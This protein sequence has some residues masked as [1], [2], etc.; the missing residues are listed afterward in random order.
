MKLLRPSLNWLLV[1][2]PVAIVAEFSHLEVL[3]FVASAL[4]IVPLAGLIGEATDQFAIRTGPRLGGLVNATFGNLTELVVGVFLIL[5]SDFEVVRASLI[6]SIVGNLLLVLGASLL[7]GGLRRSE[8]AFNR[9]AAGVHSASLLLAVVALVTPALIIATRPVSATQAHGLSMGV[10]AILIVLYVSALLF[11]QVTHSHLFGGPTPTEVPRWS[12]NRSLVVLVVSAVL[13]GYMSE[14]LVSSLRPAL[15]VLPLSPLFVGLILVPVVGNAAEHAS[16]IVFAL[17][18]KVDLTLEIAIGSSAQVALFI[19]PALVFVSLLVGHP[20]DFVFSGFE[21]AAV[22][23]A[24]LI[25]A[26]IALDGRSN[27]LE[28]AQLLGVYLIIAVGALFA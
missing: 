21:I 20:M 19:A 26:V 17:R 3:A 6:G 25:V 18:N 4:T 23:L 8:L 5:N 28:G 16:A 14:I 27:W 10:A 7:A 11:T 2:L 13:V 15:T 9:E 12:M 24:T 1:F 22:A